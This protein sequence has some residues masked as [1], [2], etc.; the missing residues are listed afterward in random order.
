MNWNYIA[1]FFDGK[2]LLTL[3]KI[4]DI[5]LELGKLIRKYWEKY[6]YLLK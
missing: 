2:A 4:T 6:N 1:R 5:K 3:G